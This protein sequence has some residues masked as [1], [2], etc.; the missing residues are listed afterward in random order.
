VAALEQQEP[1]PEAGTLALGQRLVANAFR[2]RTARPADTRIFRDLRHD[3]DL[4]PQVTEQLRFLM[5]GFHRDTNV[6]YDIQGM[7]DEGSDVLLRLQSARDARFIGIQIKSHK[8]IGLKGIVSDLREQL[9][10]SED[11]YDP[12]LRWYIFLGADISEK[13]DRATS[14]QVRNIQSAFAKKSKVTIVDPVYS[15][16]FLRLSKAQMDSLTTLTLRTGDPLVEDAA[17]DLRRHPVE[18]ALLLRLVTNAVGREDAFTTLEELDSDSWIRQ[19]YLLAHELESKEFEFDQYLLMG[20]LENEVL[21][22]LLVSEPRKRI[23]SDLNWSSRLAIHIERLS[24]VVDDGGN[25]FRAPIHLH[26]ALYALAAEGYVKHDLE[27][28]ELI[29][30]LIDGILGQ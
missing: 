2:Y 26:P 22:G 24:D 13:M 16:T 30:Y 10:R 4:V 19:R 18:A 29:E 7:S 5:E 15:V 3:A 14:R 21:H 25:M 8:E 11:R 27:F 12:L 17:A 23:N 1:D 6:T 28:D 9:S 20:D